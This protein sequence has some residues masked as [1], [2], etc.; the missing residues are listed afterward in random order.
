M[1]YKEY[2]KEVYGETKKFYDYEFESLYELVKFIN[3]NQPFPQW[4]CDLSSEN[5]DYDFTGTKDIEEAKE[6]CLNG[7]AKNVESFIIKSNDLK[8]MF[9]IKSQKRNF[10]NDVYGSRL[11]VSKALTGNPRSM[12]KLIRNEPLKHINL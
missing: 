5:D 8:S 7:N 4:G 12:Q 3:E 1:V 2:Y 11:Q 10:V 6:L 9:K